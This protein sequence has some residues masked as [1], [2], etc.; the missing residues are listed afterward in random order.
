MTKP[1]N[2]N[3]LDNVV[4]LL[5]EAKQQIVRAINQTMVISYYKIGGRMIVEEEQN[6]KERADYGKFLIKEISKGLTK[7]FVK[8]FSVTNAKQFRSF[9]ISYEKGQT[10]SDLLKKP[11]HKKLKNKKSATLSQTSSENKKPQ[12]L[13]AVFNLSWSHYLHLMRIEDIN[14][15]NYYESESFNNNWSVRELKRL[16][17][18]GLYSRIE[19]EKNNEQIF[20][21]KYK[22]VLPS[23]KELKSLI[24]S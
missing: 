16:V 22:T 19:L 4:S 18:S 3:L 11:T 15:H 24:E 14:E 2:I 23:K 13:S 6:G 12:T 17:D 1:T 5:N 7:E 8:G 20:A 21:S 9:Y 10:L